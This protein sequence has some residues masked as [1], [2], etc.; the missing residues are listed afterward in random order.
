MRNN[1]LTKGELASIDV[2]TSTQVA[3]LLEVSVRSVA[4]WCDKGWLLCHRFPTPTG[5]GGDRRIQ[6]TSLIEFLVKSEMP[7]GPLE[8]YAG[9]GP[10]LLKLAQ[11]DAVALRSKYP[12]MVGETITVD[13]QRVRVVDVH[14]LL[15]HG[16]SEYGR[17]A[18]ALEC[19]Q[20]EVRAYLSGPDAVRN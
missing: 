9:D 14:R 17:V 13:S 10:K 12:P 1:K 5:R 11:H 4:K 20:R 2:Y 3:Q 16:E 15:R 8:A 6:R 19:G 7:L 18:Y